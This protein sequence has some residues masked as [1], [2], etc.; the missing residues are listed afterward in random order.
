MPLEDYRRKRDFGR[1][2]EANH[3]LLIKHGSP[4]ELKVALATPAEN[5][6]AGDEWL[7]E[8]KYDG[9][10][11][12]ARKTGAAVWLLSRN[13]KDWT[14]RFAMIAED[15]HHLP[16][17]IV[18]DGEIVVLDP[19]GRSSFQ[20][21]Q[22]RLQG[23]P[24]GPLVY[25]VFDLLFC[26][27]VDMREI[28]LIA[29]KRQ[30]ADIIGSLPAECSIRFSDHQRGQGS[31][32]FECVCKAG[33]EGVISK[34][35]TSK[36]SG[37]RTRDW[38]KV[39]C[40]RRQEFVIGGFTRPEGGRFGF[41]A[42]LLG[43][44]TPDGELCYAGRAGSGFSEK[45]LKTM[46]LAMSELAR[47]TSPFV[48]PPSSL[49]FKGVTWTEPRMVAEISFTEWT[50]DGVL[51]HPVFQGLR[52]DKVAAEVRLEV[53]QTT[54]TGTMQVSGIEITHPERP[55]FPDAGIS[56][57]QIAE[58]YGKVAAMML[59]Y[60][61][62]RPLSVV[63]CPEGSHK[64]CFFQKHLA[65]GMS[66]QIGTISI[67]ETAGESSEYLAVQNAEGLVALAQFGVIEIHPWLS[68]R[69]RLDQP[70]M[71]VFDLD[72]GEGVPWEEVLGAAL[73]LRHIL[74]ATGLESF[75]K[76]TGGKG[77]HLVVP[78]RRGPDF[79][80]ARAFARAI[81]EKLRQENPEKLLT[82]ASKAKRA[83]KIYID[84]LRNG[85]GATAVAP[86]SLRARSGAPVATP[87]DWDSLISNRAAEATSMES[88]LTWLA[89]HGK[90]PWSGYFQ[91]RQSIPK[92]A[93]KELR[94]K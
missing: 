94:V 47:K 42:I 24:T 63:R 43:Y 92:S 32:F 9:Y 54:R 55:V 33:L 30:L 68:R 26:D 46:W 2:S 60:L 84:Y 21:L 72:P 27:A 59:P 45:Q 62:A 3:W 34:R 40:S 29:R 90:D 25:Y 74:Q 66:P 1:T 83:N 73:L 49:K 13:G 65:A 15:L 78:I 38:L 19:E 89:E 17:D 81:A 75:A 87:V 31:L 22:R 70:D 57:G 71:L 50:E 6:P 8:I 36:Y 76:R 12:L 10:R 93:L 41:G 20:L 4:E 18:L 85:R 64:K 91:V 16:G 7:H 88:M 69:D 58:Y 35:V 86:Y 14:D 80:E 11:L 61:E 53:N 77:L 52:D 48:N 28:E 37:R 79:S 23:N 67:E 5:P 44:Y 51:R 82:S 39:K 56:K